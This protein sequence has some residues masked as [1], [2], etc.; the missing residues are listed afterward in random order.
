[1]K[2]IHI[3]PTDKP[4]RLIHNVLGYGMVTK[5][6]TKSDLDLIQAQYNN[7]YI[8]ND[9]EVKEGDWFY[10]FQNN[11]VLKCFKKEGLL[12]NGYHTIYKKIIL[13][14]DQDLI[15]DGVQAIDDEFLKWFVKNP[16][17][18]KVEVTYDKDAFPY[19]VET[20]KEYGWYKIIIPQETLSYTEAAKK[21]ERIFN[22]TMMKQETIDEVN[23]NRKNLYFKKQVMN[24]YAVEEYSH[25]AYEKG[26]IKGYE[27]SNKYQLERM[28]SEED[29]IAFLDWSKSTNKKKSEYELR[30]LLHGKE[31]DSKKL[32]TIWVEQFKK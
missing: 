9:S 18:E 3:I 16:S 2:N 23:D 1:M 12:L 14:T 19:G 30:C 17:C 4:S 26:F 31:I 20:S 29:M 24:P 21:D 27:E 5:E 28:Y 13:T 22:S 8:T 15:K 7:I 11:N 25:T 10:C 6:F 32:F